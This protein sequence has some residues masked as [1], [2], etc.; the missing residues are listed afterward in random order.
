[1][2]CKTTYILAVL[3]CIILPFSAASQLV[4][5]TGQTPGQLVQNTLVG[6]G[7]TVSNVSFTGAPNAIGT[8]NGT[9]TNL[10]LNSGIVLTTGTVLNT[11]TPFGGQN[12]PHG[13]NDTGSGGTDNN[14][15]GYQQ[16]TTVAGNDTYNASVLEFDFVP[17]SDSIS[18]R[19]V[20]GSEEYPEYVNAGFNDVF[21][22]FISG[23]GFGGSYNMATIPGTGGTPVTI[24]NVNAGANSAFFV[25][26][27]DGTTAPQ[28]G[29]NYYI[30]YDG[31]TV[32][33]SAT[34][35]VQCGE[36]YHLKIA[37]ADVGDG[38]LD[39][40]IFLEANSLVSHSP[41]SINANLGL[42]AFGDNKS[43]A[44]G[45]ETATISITRDPNNS[46]LASTIFLTTAGTATEGVDY[47]NVPPSVTFSPGQSSVTF[48]I[49]VIP[50]VII[51]GDEIIKL[52][53][54]QPDP[55]GNSN[56]IELELIIKEIDPIT[57]ELFSDTVHCPGDPIDLNPVISGGLPAPDYIYDWSTNETTPTITFTTNQTASVT[58][59]VSDV[60]NST[61]VTTTI[62]VVVPIYDAMTIDVPNDTSVL[63]PN[64]PVALSA[65]ASGGD[66]SYF[67]DWK[68][69]NLTFGSGPNKNVS[70]MV[71]STYI[72]RA[73]DGCND[74]IIDSVKITVLTPVLTI[75]I[76]PDQLIC[77]GAEAQL[78]VKAFGGLGGFTYNWAHS[79]ETTPIVTVQ[80]DRSTEYL[81]YVSDACATYSIRGETRVDVTQPRA[82]F[83]VISS[84]PTENLLVS[85]QNKSSG[86]VA[87]EWDFGNG[88]TSNSLSPNTTYSPWGNYDVEL[89][90]TS[91]IGCKDTIQKN[92]FI[93]PEFYF[94]A[95][96]AFTPDNDNY[97]N[98][99]EISLIGGVDFHFLIYNRWGELIFESY[100]PNFSWNGTYNRELVPD[101]VYVFKCQVSNLVG[102]RR[103]YEG[104]ITVLK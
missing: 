92:I 41:V 94:Y 7:V 73:M 5:T 31:F 35:A 40:G 80:P 76:D 65:Q 6:N 47:S 30:Q 51:E 64:T 85:F 58:L 56:F 50:D 69:G 84:D 67:Y 98:R 97:N 16:L 88:E 1:M 68:I 89:I 79:G 32:V 71:T 81:V 45:C 44:E 18:F 36:T 52:I 96:N 11:S 62:D 19:Y 60:C 86:G 28:N 37:I 12:G 2:K 27:G 70:P 43:M 57:V 39:S 34:A 25:N 13:P 100:D 3:S 14:T 17:N 20:F 61:P 66:G 24:D 10:G 77:V 9:N 87:W 90:V 78:E 53:L 93:G 26:N 59:T 38:G 91:E 74:S 54:D 95:P 63:C 42:N 99:Y 82:S 46:T 104:F 49:D 8:F 22:F 21:A 15:P 29:S 33:I 102:F 55:C 83:K 75:A 72:I 101:D 23:P 103:E 48:T 4:T